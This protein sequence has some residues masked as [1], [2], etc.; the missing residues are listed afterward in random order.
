MTMFH[1][2]WA[3]TLASYIGNVQ[4]IYR[5]PVWETSY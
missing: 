2:H 1:I 4:E 3:E 5:F